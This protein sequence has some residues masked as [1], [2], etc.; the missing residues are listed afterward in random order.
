MLR[1]RRLG[2]LRAAG[3]AVGIGL[4][5]VPGTASAAPGDEVGA[6]AQDAEDAAAEV[7][8]LL[9]Q[10]GAAQAAAD[11]ADARAARAEDELAAMRQASADAR[12]EARGAADAA[13]R[14]QAELAAARDAVARFARSSYMSGS[15]SPLLEGLLTADGPAQMMER[16]ALLAAAGDHRGSA[17]AGAANARQRAVEARTAA[18]RAVTEAD[19]LQQAARAAVEAAADARAEAD[20]VVAGLREQQAAAEQELAQVRAALLDLQQQRDAAERASRASSPPPASPPPS[21]GT[22]SPAPPPVS[23]AR[24]WD[25][26]AQCESGGNWSINTGNGYYGGLQFS[27]STWL[28]YGGGSYAPRADL[29]TREQQ[30]AVAEKVLAGQG[31]GAWPTCGRNL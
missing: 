9:E 3:L 21:G 18:Q 6:V 4:L 30:I 1:R 13:Q 20:R 26:V 2:R 16:A 15:S 31:R 8:R 10:T 17:V 27:S 14:A 28:G 22:S 11:E 29:A 25:A 12:A 19:R 7:S 5:V 24:N 23:S